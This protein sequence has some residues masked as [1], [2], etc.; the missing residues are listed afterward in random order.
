MENVSI[1]VDKVFAGITGCCSVVFLAPVSYLIWVHYNNF[2]NNKT[3]NER[4]GQKKRMGQSRVSIISFVEKKQSFCEN[5]ASMCCN[6]GSTERT[7]AEFRV[8]MRSDND[9]RNVIGDIDIG[10]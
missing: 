5:Y 3:T 1:I 10:S 7:T 2:K 8:A 6:R 9:Y 4:Y